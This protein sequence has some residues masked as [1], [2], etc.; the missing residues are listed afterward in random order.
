MSKRW[1]NK[2][3]IISQRFCFSYCG[4][5]QIFGGIFLK[6]MLSKT[7]KSSF[8][9]YQ[10]AI[11][12]VLVEI[13]WLVLTCWQWVWQ[14]K[15]LMVSLRLTLWN[16]FCWHLSHLLGDHHAEEEQ[17]DSF[18]HGLLLNYN[19]FKGLVDLS[20]SEIFLRILVTKLQMASRA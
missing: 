3:E 1:K 10:V 5:V 7:L 11:S 12:S 14:M 8:S 20:C 2:M 19:G 17:S 9:K 15:I 13:T 4:T 6:A 18:R 16:I